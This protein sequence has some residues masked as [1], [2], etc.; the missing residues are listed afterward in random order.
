MAVK[1]AKIPAEV[2]I[3]AYRSRVGGN[4]T[5]AHAQTWARGLVLDVVN[6]ALNGDSTAFD[7]LH[8]S[9]ELES[10][11]RNHHRARV[12]AGDE[13]DNVVSSASPRPLP[14]P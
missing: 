4:V 9:P 11:A 2:A 7:R 8:F 6:D 5:A 1:L 13:P 14:K 10:A 12:L 3:A